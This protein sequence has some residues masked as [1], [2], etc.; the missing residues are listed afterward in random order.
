MPAPTQW[1][2]VAS[3]L[4]PQGRKGEVLADLLTDFPERFSADSRVYLGPPEFSGPRSAARETKI[5][6]FWLPVGKNAG[7]VVLHL[8]G[9]DSI[10]QAELLNGLD[11]IVPAEERIELAP[12]EVYVSDLLGCRLYDVGSE[13]GEVTEIQFPA[14]PDGLRRIEDVAP[15]LTVRT[16]D[17]DEVLVPFVKDFLLR[18]DTDA[19]RLEMR[20]PIGLVDLNKRRVESQAE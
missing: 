3:I 11:V 10:S 20:L 13:I 7:R 8:D 1:I 19:M 6:R 16:P 12:D 5:K 15:L 9:F 14:T 4:R 17:G 18:L 2:V